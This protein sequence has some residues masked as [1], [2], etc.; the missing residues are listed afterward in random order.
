MD[1]VREVE[2]ECILRIEKIWKDIPK[3]NSVHPRRK[4]MGDLV[5]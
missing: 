2:R 4:E 5:F 1:W 3:L